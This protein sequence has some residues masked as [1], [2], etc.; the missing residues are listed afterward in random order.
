MASPELSICFV[1]LH[2]LR[3][4]ADV[5]HQNECYKLHL[6]MRVSCCDCRQL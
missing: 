5:M 6:L 4:D 3:D 1:G 2:S